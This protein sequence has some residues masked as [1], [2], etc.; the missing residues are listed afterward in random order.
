MIVIMRAA[1]SGKPVGIN[2]TQVRF[3]RANADDVTA[4]VFGKSGDEHSVLV[5][6]GLLRVAEDLNMALRRRDAAPAA[7]EDRRSLQ[8]P[9]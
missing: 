3:L 6:G 1:A 5:K 7:V 2:V 4:I 9:A 8:R